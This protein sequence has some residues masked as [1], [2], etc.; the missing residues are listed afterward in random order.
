MIWA[1]SWRNVWRN[2]LRSAVIIMAIAIG[3][4][5]GA[6]T[7]A[8]YRGMVIQR[9]QAAIITESSHIQLHHKEYLTNPDQKYIIQG[10]D[11]I[12]SVI[13]RMPEVKAVTQRVLVSAMI[14]SA[15]TGSGVKVYGI[16]PGK[17]KRVT[18]L[19]LKIKEGSYLDGKKTP[20]IMG[21]KLAAK[22]SVKLRSRVVLTLQTMDGTLTSGLF[23]VGGIYK[24]NNSVY[25]ETHV[26]VR[27]NDLD[28]IIGLDDH[29]CQEIAVLL[30]NNEDLGLATNAVKADFPGLDTKTWRELMPEVD[31]VEQSMDISMYF[32][33]GIV[34]AAL[35]FGIINTMLMAVLERVKELG[36]LMA[37]GMNRVR[38]FLMILLETILLSLTG[39]MIGLVTGYLVTLLFWHKGIDL[40]AFAEGYEKLGYESIIY[41]VPNLDIDVKVAVMVLITGIL[42]AIYPAWKAIRLK[43]AEA[44][45]MDN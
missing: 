41:P 5:A 21:E 16:E 29:S 6:F 33:M 11:S 37:V 19:F 38:I 44:L 4:F 30:K 17:E 34:L 7:W 42:A 24:T 35:V 28:A 18:N 8:F 43:P 25:D 39:G 36:M 27:R 1:V 13:A 12:A 14:S 3:I 10:A 9:I 22:L 40:S 45:H 32:F 26:F 2:K 15:E 20:I 31:L 23:R